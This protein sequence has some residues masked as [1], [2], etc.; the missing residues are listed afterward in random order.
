MISIVR[1]R[2]K[3]CMLADIYAFTWMPNAPMPHNGGTE[4]MRAYTSSQVVSPDPSIFSFHFDDVCSGCVNISYTRIHRVYTYTTYVHIRTF[5]L[6]SRYRK[7][8]QEKLAVRMSV[9]IYKRSS[10]SRLCWSKVAY[11][12]P[13]KLSNIDANVLD[14]IHT[15]YSWILF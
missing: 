7:L 10:S 3:S 13:S 8:S 14:S 4:D 11:K 6:K 15:V 1:Y 2:W 5:E 12:I 9:H